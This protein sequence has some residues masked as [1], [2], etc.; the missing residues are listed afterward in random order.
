MAKKLDIE[1]RPTVEEKVQETS[2][3]ILT[4]IDKLEE[5]IHAMVN[6]QGVL[7]RMFMAEIGTQFDGRLPAMLTNTHNGMVDLFGR[8]EAL[9]TAL[10]EGTYWRNVEH[11]LDDANLRID[12]GSFEMRIDPEA[13]KTLKEEY[14]AAVKKRTEE[15]EAKLVALQEEALAERRRQELGIVTP[16]RG[17]ANTILKGR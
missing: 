9:E 10:T 11:D 8:V 5:I 3:S 6:N 1:R 12:D 4:R 13:L 2:V 17:E 16:S 7:Q 15:Y 14:D